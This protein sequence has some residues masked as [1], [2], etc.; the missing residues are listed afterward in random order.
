MRTHFHSSG[1]I[2]ICE[3]KKRLNSI[4]LLRVKKPHLKRQVTYRRLS[5]L[6]LHG[7]TYAFSHTCIARTQANLLPST[8]TLFMTVSLYCYIWV[9]NV[10]SAIA[11]SHLSALARC[12]VLH[13][14]TETAKLR[15]YSFAIPVLYSRF[16]KLVFTYVKDRTRGGYSNSAI[17]REGA[18]PGK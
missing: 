3:T 13:N 1:V 12:S 6:V 16:K 14:Q 4:I 15:L 10:T 9:L 11:V 5:E 17:E 18:S 2:H 8:C 7:H